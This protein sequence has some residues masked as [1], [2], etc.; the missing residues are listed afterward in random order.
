[1]TT[2]QDPDVALQKLWERHKPN[3]PLWSLEAIGELLRGFQ[4]GVESG[5][6][7][8]ILSTRILF[9]R[10][11]SPPIQG[12]ENGGFE[13]VIGEL[14]AVDVG[15]I[16]LRAD[17][18]LWSAYGGLLRRSQTRKFA[19]RFHLYSITDSSASVALHGLADG[20]GAIHHSSGAGHDGGSSK[21]FIDSERWSDIKAWLDHWLPQ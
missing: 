9:G 6:R 8:S 7:Q 17:W 13:E 20:T 1:M 12:A 19:G 11:I 18:R 16:F 5:Q 15:T 3:Y 14:I 10:T 4:P 2:A 21:L